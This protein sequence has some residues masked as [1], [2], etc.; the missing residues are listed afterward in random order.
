MAENRLQELFEK[1]SATAELYGATYVGVADLTPAQDAIVAQG[2]EMLRRYPRAISM[3]IALMDSIVDEL[4]RIRQD[5]AVAVNY[6][7]QGYGIV[8]NRLDMLASI[9]GSHVQKAGWAS[10][11]I[12]ASERYDSER[13]MAVFSHKL[14]ARH[15][16]FGWIG[17]SCMLITPEHGPRV[18]W[19]TVLT[20]APLQPTGSPMAQRCGDCTAC[21]DICP[22]HAYTGRNYVEGEPREAR[23]RAWDCEA[24]FDSLVTAGDEKACGLCLYAC[25]HG[26]HGQGAR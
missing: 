7:H 3:G 18:R 19:I 10:L 15:V 25:P 11:P 9:V 2:G 8:N 24:Y 20:D 6:L 26:R 5:R 22:A 21:V 17:K 16:G 23:F 1:I 12:P 4:P 13:I 14:A